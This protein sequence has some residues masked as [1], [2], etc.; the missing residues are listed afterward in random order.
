M[1][2]T[3]RV[4]MVRTRLLS[5]AHAGSRRVVTS[6]EPNVV[7]QRWRRGRRYGSG[8]SESEYLGLHLDLLGIQVVAKVTYY[9]AR[10]GNPLTCPNLAFIC[11]SSNLCNTQAVA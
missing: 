8:K 3:M 11:R 2:E 7:G 9:N 10:A 1:R 6:A 5:D 4:H